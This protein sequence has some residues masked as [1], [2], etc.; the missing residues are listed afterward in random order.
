[1]EFRSGALTSS[2][3]SLTSSMRCD[4]LSSLLSRSDEEGNAEMGEE[5]EIIT[6]QDTNLIKDLGKIHLS[7][8]LTG[9]FNISV[10]S[11]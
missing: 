10:L 7:R 9:Q 11:E 8:S 4:D 1:M 3:S 2:T 6:T 5:K